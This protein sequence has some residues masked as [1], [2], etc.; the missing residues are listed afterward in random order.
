MM[1]DG[2]IGPSCR[3]NADRITGAAI[4]SRP[5]CPARWSNSP[6]GRGTSLR[7]KIF[8]SAATCSPSRRSSPIRP[9]KP[10]NRIILADLKTALQ[11]GNRQP[12]KRRRVGT[13][14]LAGIGGKGAAGEQI[15]AGQRQTFGTANSRSGRGI[16]VA[17]G[18]SRARIEK[19]ADHR[20]VEFGAGRVRCR[21]ASY[22]GRQ[23][24]PSGRRRRRQNAA[25]ANG[26]AH[27]RPDRPFAWPQAPDRRL[28]RAWPDRSG[29]AAAGL[30]GQFAAC[31]APDPAPLWRSTRQGRPLSH[32]MSR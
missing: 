18:R 11:I 28:H 19:H 12:L 8:G 9:L 17:P 30:P 26:T 24:R 20:E 23:W 21:R 31:D 27:R 1:R 6:P 3:N 13:Q 16:A 29:N 10:D 5:T 15:E 32:L 4:D 22:G 7:A 25:S 14:R 2:Q